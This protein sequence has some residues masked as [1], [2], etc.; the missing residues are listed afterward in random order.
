MGY[1]II[2]L[3]LA[4]GYYGNAGSP[5]EIVPQTIQTPRKQK[6]TDGPFLGPAIRRGH[7]L[8]RRQSTP[9]GVG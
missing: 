5:P 6:M 3:E 1:I 9:S 7:R 2:G 4:I 8:E